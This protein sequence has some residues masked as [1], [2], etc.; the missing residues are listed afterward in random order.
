M[1]NLDI[2][3]ERNREFAAGQSAA[4][5]LMPSLPRA[6]PHVKAVIIGCAGYACG[7]GRDPRNQAGRGGR[8]SQYRGP[9]HPG[10]VG[11][12]GAARA[13]WPGCR[14]GSGRRQGVSPDRASSHRL[15]HHPPRRRPREAGALF[16]NTRSR[17]EGKSGHGPAASS[18][19]VNVALL[20]SIPALPAK[21]I[22]S[23]LVYDV[24]TGLVETVVPPAPIRAA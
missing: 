19:A 6:M 15:R 21:W 10:A 9:N 14:R 3:L 16:P 18:V 1:S 12:I 5:T 22:V 23:G 8:H 11:G 13:N 4:G 20:K 2:M 24:A 17:S 7:A